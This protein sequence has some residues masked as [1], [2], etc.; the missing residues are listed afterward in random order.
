MRRYSLPDQKHGCPEQNYKLR[1]FG[2]P[3]A[4][5]TVMHL[6]KDSGPDGKNR[7]PGV[8]RMPGIL[9]AILGF[10]WMSMPF[11]QA[12]EKAWSLVEHNQIYSPHPASYPKQFLTRLARNSYRPTY[13]PKQHVLVK[14][15]FSP[16]SEAELK[17]PSGHFCERCLRERNPTSADRNFHATSHS[18]P[19]EA[20]VQSGAI[21]EFESGLKL[22]GVQR[23]WIKTAPR[24]KAD[25][26]LYR[27]LVRVADKPEYPPL[28]TAVIGEGK[29]SYSRTN[30]RIGYG[31]MVADNFNT[32]G[33][34]NGNHLEEP[35]RF[36]VKTTVN[37]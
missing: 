3:D 1:Q 34:R 29:A 11:A 13:A 22:A 25:P 21:S 36:Y 20:I 10:V 18:N 9:S 12:A 24:P 33:I 6:K 2:M 19:E 32:V 31:H 4:N 23:V 8:S 17:H 5:I 7:R 28:V 16:T 15:A 37:F 35:S 26:A 27:Q 30:F 14:A